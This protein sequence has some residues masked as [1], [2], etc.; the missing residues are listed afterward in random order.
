MRAEREASPPLA[1]VEMKT[2]TECV[3]EARMFLEW[4]GDWRRAQQ[5]MAGRHYT[6]GWTDAQW[7]ELEALVGHG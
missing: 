2:P 5:D 4:R 3:A 6:I 7:D 1:P